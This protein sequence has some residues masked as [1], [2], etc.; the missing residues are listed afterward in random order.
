[1]VGKCIKLIKVNI[2]AE[3]TLVIFFKILSLIK[4]RTKE[5]PIRKYF[6]F[7]PNLSRVVDLKIHR[8]NIF[9]G[10][11]CVPSYLPNVRPFYFRILNSN[12]EF[13]RDLGT[14]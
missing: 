13:E 7:R 8:T 12:F 2:P 5:I 3:C 9:N 14:V 11:C 6:V 4:L 1:M 10:K